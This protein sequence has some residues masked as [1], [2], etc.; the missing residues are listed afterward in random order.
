[1]TVCPTGASYKRTE[2]GIVLVDEDLCIGCKLCAWACPYGARE[3]DGGTGVMKKCTLCIDRIYNEHLADPV[4][5][6]VS[7]CP[8]RARHF[9][10]L[11]DPG[12]EVSRLVAD[13]GGYELMPETGCRPTNRYLP[14]RSREPAQPAAGA[15][16]AG[17]A[18]TLADA[19][20]EGGFLG[21]IDRL[22]SAAENR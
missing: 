17:A 14:P 15:G 10:D 19:P 20:A 21:W 11:A 5:A 16:A 12:S 2:D 6:C 4:P 1:M 3:F 18:P 7:T 8:A 9:G 13:R 22:L